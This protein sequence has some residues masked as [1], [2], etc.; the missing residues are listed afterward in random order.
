METFAVVL[1]SLFVYRGL[2]TAYAY[3]VVLG[4]LVPQL[5]DETLE[6][7]VW[8]AIHD[9]SL[10]DP[11]LNVTTVVFETGCNATGTLVALQ[12]FASQRVT[13]VVGPTCAEACRHSVPFGALQQWTQVTAGCGAYVVPTD[14]I[15]NRVYQIAP[16]DSTKLL[17]AELVAKTYTGGGTVA[18][19]V[20]WTSDW[21]S[22]LASL[23]GVV[24]SARWFFYD[25]ST[26]AAVLV[27][28]HATPEVKIIAFDVEPSMSVTSFVSMAQRS[29][30]ALLGLSVDLD[31][32]LR[33]IPL[34]QSTSHLISIA[35]SKS[36]STNLTQPITVTS[37]YMYDA[38]IT[39]CRSQKPSS[40]ALSAHTGASGAIDWIQRTRAPLFQLQVVP[41]SGG[42]AV[43]LGTFAPV[44]S[45][46]VYTDSQ[47]PAAAPVTWSTL[48][49]SSSPGTSSPSKTLPY[50]PSILGA[51]CLSSACSLAFLIRM[52]LPPYWLVGMF[53]AGFDRQKDTVS[54][55]TFQVYTV[56]EKDAAKRR[57]SQVLVVQTMLDVTN[58]GLGLAVYFGFVIGQ[59]SSIPR[60]AFY[61]IALGSQVAFLPSLLSSRMPMILR[62]TK[63]RRFCT[64][65]NKVAANTELD[66]SFPTHNHHIGGVVVAGG[67]RIEIPAVI[68]GLESSLRYIEQEHLDVASSLLRLWLEE[69][70]VLGINVY[71]LLEGVVS[72]T[73]AIVF[74]AT[75]GTMVATGFKLH[76]VNRLS[77]LYFKRRGVL[78]DIA[79][80]RLESKQRRSSYN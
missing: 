24:P 78:F 23:R 60:I 30:V 64:K 43:I 49:S 2:P 3:D 66:Y 39:A 56:Q 7:A 51:I 12:A 46:L 11:A 19:V 59:D 63:Y 62:Y 52:F 70:P 27:A 33:A 53:F 16:P 41:A 32:L 9:A 65:D 44:G 58:L 21:V 4:V 22:T 50:G 71:Y 67:T 80:A 37:A 54:E 28:V 75:F 36:P 14:D 8:S 45:T 76:L 6:Q 74:V 35:F 79:M 69:V 1:A 72:D 29:T 10:D 20:P 25:A 26:L 34:F 18:Y 42:V 77:E 48:L 68:F 40:F 31:L 5:T 17:A 55:D 57:N 15:Y 47:P 61:S 38:T 13:A 73:V